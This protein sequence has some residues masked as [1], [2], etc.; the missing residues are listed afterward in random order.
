[1]EPEAKKPCYLCQ[2]FRTVFVFT[3]GVIVGLVGA[4]IF[5]VP[6]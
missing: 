3:F 4:V 2:I 6:R 1:M 5:F